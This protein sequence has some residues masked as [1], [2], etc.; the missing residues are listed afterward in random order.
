MCFSIML[1]VFIWNTGDFQKKKE[2]KKEEMEFLGSDSEEEEEEEEERGV[3]E[4]GGWRGSETES[5]EESD[6]EEEQRGKEQAPGLGLPSALQLLGGEHGPPS[7]LKKT[8]QEPVTLRE[9]ILEET[10]LRW[11]EKAA[12]ARRTKFSLFCVSERR[13]KGKLR[14][15]TPTSRLHPYL[16]LLA[17]PAGRER[18]LAAGSARLHSVEK[19]A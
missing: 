4:A 8:C 1:R 15:G 17:P 2:K 12:A 5:S 11:A 7:F 14:D 9:Q 6:H 3:A 19:G 10:P 13:A 16:C 18:L